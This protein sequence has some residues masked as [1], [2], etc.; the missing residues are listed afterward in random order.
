[1]I[2]RFCIG[3]VLLAVPASAL[4]LATTASARAADPAPLPSNSPGASGAATV[5]DDP[6]HL[7]ELAASLQQKSNTLCWELHRYHQQQPDFKDAYRNAKELWSLSGKYREALRASDAP[8][9]NDNVARMVDLFNRVQ[10]TVNGWGDGVIQS[11]P[12]PTPP[13]E[14]R[15]V[16]VPGS[17][18]NVN[19]PLLF[20]GGIQVGRSPQ[21]VVTEPKQPEFR[22]R[23][24]HAHARGSK[25]SLERELLTTQLALQYLAEDTGFN[26]ANSP[27]AAP[28]AGIAPPAADD[29]QPNP[30]EP[31][32]N[33]SSAT[34]GPKLSPPL[35]ISPPP[36]K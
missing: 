7:D 30:S 10:T 20:G 26:P 13:Q 29:P 27:G 2:T 16:V 8:A 31:V 5:L 28:G 19:I 17:G 24:P 35:R 25:R 23:R 9:L 3:A 34:T 22:M 32:P 18:M 21:V 11:T 15:V 6:A 14:E 12:T 36:K 33:V 4:Y 1:M